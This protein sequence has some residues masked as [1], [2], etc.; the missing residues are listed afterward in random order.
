MLEYKNSE[1]FWSGFSLQEIAR[2]WQTPVYVYNRSVI[3]ND[4]NRIKRIFNKTADM[5][6]YAVKANSNIEIIKI[7]AQSGLGA[8]IVSTGELFAALK[9]DI[10][11]NN[12][13]FAGT[14]KTDEELIFAIKSRIFSLN[15]ESDEELK[16]VETFANTM[17]AKQPVMLRVNPSV[18][19]ESHPYISTGHF[20]HKFGIDISEIEELAKYCN[21]SHSLHFQGLHFHI[22]SQVTKLQAVEESFKI[23]GQIVDRIENSGIRVP[24][25]DIGGGLPVDYYSD[26][27]RL[28]N[29]EMPDSI[30]EIHKLY[31][32]WADA[33]VKY[34]DKEKHK[35]LFEPGRALVAN[36][37]ILLT[38]IL[39]RKRHQDKEFIITDAGMNDLIRP[40][41]YQAFHGI[42]PLKDPGN[43]KIKADIAGPICETG[44]FFA[45]DILVPECG[46]GD[47]LA[48]LTTGA[49]GYSESSNYNL[50]LKPLELL[51]ENDS[52][53]C[54]RERQK[55]E[56]I[57]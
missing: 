23:I 30:P 56:D 2:E 37:G 27:S 5:T 26:Y 22:G 57:L 40:A 52:I 3:E 24:F 12:I 39:Y 38:K 32:N 7:A 35:I 46:R 51:I 29:V 13:I 55:Y 49:Y 9:A 18:D 44:D 36:G 20:T 45:H 47:Y 11:H 19:P 31:E 25:V 48:I 6:C 8:D 15:V 21:L 41:L 54:I 50:R 53:R 4:I 16:A 33:A 14:G 43:K 1:L 42:V 10:P 17:L 28:L 34:I